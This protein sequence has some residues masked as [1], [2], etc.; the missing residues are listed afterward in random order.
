MLLPVPSLAASATV[1]YLAQPVPGAVTVVVVVAWIGVEAYAARG[2]TRQRDAL[3]DGGTKRF[4]VLTL[5]AGLAAAIAIALYSHRASFH[6]VGETG[7]EPATPGPPD[8]PS[9]GQR[10]WP[11]ANPCPCRGGGGNGAVPDAGDG[12]AASRGEETTAGIGEVS[13]AL[14]HGAVHDAFQL[15]G[16]RR[17]A[18]ARHRLKQ[19]PV[20]DRDAAA[21][22][23]DGTVAL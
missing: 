13:G 14:Q 19:L 6:I 11:R 18:L 21:C 16:D 8:P 3:Q 15:G 12:V 23:T 4:L 9:V 1:L 7:L 22:V 2:G 5:Y 10:G 20:D 17:V